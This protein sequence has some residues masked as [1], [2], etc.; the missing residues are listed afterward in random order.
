MGRLPG[1]AD[2]SI[3]ALAFSPDGKLLA[4]GGR[5]AT[6]LLW[7]V[8]RARLLHLWEELGSGKDETGKAAKKMAANPKEAVLFLLERLRR[9]AHAESQAQRFIT[10]LDSPQFQVREKGTLELK[11][12]GADAAFALQLALSKQSLS[13]EARRRIDALLGKLKGAGTALPGSEP[14]SVLLSVSILA[15]INNGEALQVL[16]ELAEGPADSTVAHQ[17]RAALE[18]LKK[19][20][21]KR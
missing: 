16:R 7:N 4:S 20:P 1:H 18:K 5:D 15:E 12:L 8:A 3:L 17:A 6:V 13:L 9:A 19:T 10:M 14:R 21:D 11:K 2:S